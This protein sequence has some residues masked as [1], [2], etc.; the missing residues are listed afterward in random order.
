M[1]KFIN[2][3]SNIALILGFF[4]QDFT[5]FLVDSISQSLERL[6]VLVN[7]PLCVLKL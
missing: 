3:Y 2:K 6:S 4:F 1:H 7:P 5:M